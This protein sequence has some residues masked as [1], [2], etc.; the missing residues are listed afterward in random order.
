M[1]Q[2]LHSLPVFLFFFFFLIFFWNFTSKAPFTWYANRVL[3]YAN[4]FFFQVHITLKT[5][6]GGQ[7][8]R[9][10]A[11]GIK[12]EDGDRDATRL[13]KC[14]FAFREQLYNWSLFSL[15]HILYV[16]FA[17]WSRREMTFFCFARSAKWVAAQEFGSE[18]GGMLST[19]TQLRLIQVGWVGRH[20]NRVQVCV[21]ACVCLFMC[22]WVTVCVKIANVLFGVW[23]RKKN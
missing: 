7:N 13:N 21:N 19:W 1:V 4:N 20:L 10:Q 9:S 18:G 11:V 12:E 17:T 8:Q 23:W 16:T 15:L 22:V 2:R 3:S 14:D 5:K 6:Q